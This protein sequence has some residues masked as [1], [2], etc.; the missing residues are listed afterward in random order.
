LLVVTLQAALGWCDTKTVQPTYPRNHSLVIDTM[1]AV[2]DTIGPSD[3]TVV[4]CTAAAAD[5]D[6]DSLFYDW[7][8]D[9]RLNTQGTPTWNK[10]FN[11]QLSPSQKFYNADLPNPINDSA[12]VYCEVRD[13]RGGGAGRHVFIILRTN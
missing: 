13:A 6:G 4:T 10:Y 1:V 3:S 12:W 5:A 11:N 7:Q 2:P 8:T 9:A